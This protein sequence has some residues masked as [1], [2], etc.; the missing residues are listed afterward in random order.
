MSNIIM[1]KKAYVSQVNLLKVNKKLS[2]NDTGENK[3]KITAKTEESITNKPEFSLK[4]NGLDEPTIKV[5]GNLD[6]NIP[7]AIIKAGLLNNDNKEIN[8][9]VEW[10]E[11]NGIKPE[12]TWISSSV[13]RIRSPIILC[14]FL[15]S[16]IK[17]K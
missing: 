16:N 13:L 3:S 2:K 17:F 1:Q 9:L 11:I 10:K 14:D 8:C 6:N 4:E 12:S 5:K 15:L 7:L